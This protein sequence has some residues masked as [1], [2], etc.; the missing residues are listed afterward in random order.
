MTDTARC[1]HHNAPPQSVEEGRREGD[2]DQEMSV[3]AR[4][5][6]SPRL[7]LP[8][9]HA[10]RHA[11]QQTG[12][13]RHTQQHRVCVCVPQGQGRS[14]QRLLLTDDSVPR[15]IPS[16]SLTPTP[17]IQQERQSEPGTSQWGVCARVQHPE[18][19]RLQLTGTPPNTTHITLS[20]HAPARIAS[21]A[22]SW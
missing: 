8:H 13:D 16:L 7:L 6:A 19:V 18:A 5:S 1:L 22:A 4:N 20:C 9:S 3:Q 21:F 12:P 2:E 14:W 17:P 10:L 11:G 15:T